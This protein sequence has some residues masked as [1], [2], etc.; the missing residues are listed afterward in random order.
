MSTH[1]IQQPDP[2]AKG[3]H[4]PAMKGAD[5]L[6]HALEREG[7]DTV[8]A[9]PGGA[10]M[11]LHQSLTR[12]KKIRTILP[13][14]EQGGGFMAHGYARAT[15]RAGVCMATSYPGQP[16]LSPV[17]QTLTWIVYPWLRLPARSTNSS[18]G[19]LLF[20]KLIFSG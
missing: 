6:V 10:S 2:E 7:V 14:Q 20:R 8:F 11:E 1:P 16:I 4:G 5:V 18:L 19:R 17:L 15:G 3:E 12:S 13:R 9:Y